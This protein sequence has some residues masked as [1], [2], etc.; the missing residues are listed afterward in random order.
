MAIDIQVAYSEVDRKLVYSCG[1]SSFLGANWK[2]P[3]T[4]IATTSVVTEVRALLLISYKAL[5]IILIK[6]SKQLT[7]K[8]STVLGAFL[9]TMLVIAAEYNPQNN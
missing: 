4:K 1:D 6:N 7:F 9:E 8:F 3:V 2:I 5:D